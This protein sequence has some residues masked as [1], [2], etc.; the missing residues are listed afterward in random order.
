MFNRVVI[1]S[2]TPILKIT[3]LV[4]HVTPV[5]QLEGKRR[6][7]FGAAGAFRQARAQLE[8]PTSA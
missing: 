1:G 4:P 3:R 6:E 2:T 7:S 8:Q 5:T